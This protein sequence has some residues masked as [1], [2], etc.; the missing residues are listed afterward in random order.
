MYFKLLLIFIIIPMIEL[1]VL[2]KLGEIIGLLPTLLLIVGTGIVGASLARSQGFK[3]LGRIKSSFRQNSVPADHLVEGLLILV[4]GVLLL[5]P[6]LLTDITGFVFILPGTRNI[7]G[8]YVKKKIAEY[9]QKGNIHFGGFQTDFYKEHDINKDKEKI[10]D[11]EVEDQE[12][13]QKF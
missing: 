9:I 3:I 13:N 6:G 4:G 11:I 2:V 7:I 10:V 12:E 5:T 1:L 8:R